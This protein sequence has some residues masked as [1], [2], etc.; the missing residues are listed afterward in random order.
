MNGS[1]RLQTGQDVMPWRMGY[2]PRISIAYR[3]DTG[4][5]TPLSSLVFFKTCPGLFHETSAGA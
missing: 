1:F 3:Q 2:N 4:K 5:A